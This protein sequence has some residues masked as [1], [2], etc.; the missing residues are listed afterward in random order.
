MTWIRCEGV[1]GKLRPPLIQPYYPSYCCR[2]MSAFQ[3]TQQNMDPWKRTVVGHCNDS[4]VHPWYGCNILSTSDNGIIKPKDEPGH[5]ERGPRGDVRIL[6][7]DLLDLLT[8]W[9]PPNKTRIP[10]FDDNHVI[11]PTLEMGEIGG[12]LGS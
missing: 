7:S 10:G 4:Y 5:S 3:A 9:T 1:H 11:P 8:N 12:T 2:I 6:P